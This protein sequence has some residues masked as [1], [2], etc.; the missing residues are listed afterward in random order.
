MS[1]KVCPR[2]QIGVIGAKKRAGDASCDPMGD[3]SPGLVF[4]RLVDRVEGQPLY[5]SHSRIPSGLGR[6]ENPL[7]DIIDVAK[8]SL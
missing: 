6:A 7:E 1:A 4:R 3:S 2:L 5:P 8:L